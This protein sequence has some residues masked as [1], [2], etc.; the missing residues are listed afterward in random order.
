MGKEEGDGCDRAGC[1]EVSRESA[2][3]DLGVSA[4]RDDDG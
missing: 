3:A 2:S 4:W 1:G